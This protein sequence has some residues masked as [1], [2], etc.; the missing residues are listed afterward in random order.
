MSHTFR[1][2]QEREFFTPERCFI[3]ELLNRDANR[4]LSVSQARV[5]PG[6]TTALHALKDVQELYYILQGSGD[7]EIDRR[8]AGRVQK[9]DLVLIP[10][11]SPQRITNTGTE[12]LLFLCICTPRFYP[13]CYQDLE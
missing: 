13:A 8:P 12:D 1:T 11:G 4:D 9:G 6:V 2:F 7:M 10:A 3:T 5:Q